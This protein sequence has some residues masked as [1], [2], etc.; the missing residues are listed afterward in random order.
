MPSAYDARSLEEPYPSVNNQS[1]LE[2]RGEP[3]LRYGSPKT[4][5]Q[6]GRWELEC[7]ENI[8]EKTVC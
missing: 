5:S 2:W 7:P 4:I 6:R 8:L 1:V 3:T